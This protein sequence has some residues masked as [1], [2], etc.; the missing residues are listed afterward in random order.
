MSS[1]LQIFLFNFCVRNINLKEDINKQ[2]FFL[3]TYIFNIIS[4]FS[5]RLFSICK[6]LYSSTLAQKVVFKW[7][8]EVIKQLI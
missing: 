1:S 8:K 7:E 4:Y 6:S 3:S 2:D 5:L